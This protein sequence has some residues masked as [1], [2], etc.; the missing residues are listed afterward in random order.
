MNWRKSKQPVWSCDLSAGDTLSD[1][2]NRMLCHARLRDFGLETECRN[3]R[4]TD[5]SKV[6]WIVRRRA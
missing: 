1:H 2:Q 4:E 6:V 3:P 5:A